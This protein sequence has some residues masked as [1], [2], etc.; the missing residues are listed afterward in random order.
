MA[1]CHQLKQ[2]V[3]GRNPD[4]HEGHIQLV[5]AEGLSNSLFGHDLLG[6]M[7]AMLT[8]GDR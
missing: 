8:T 3:I 6:K 5:I 2:L 7:G 1:L 4:G